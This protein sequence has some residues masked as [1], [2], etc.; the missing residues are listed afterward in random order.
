MTIHPTALVD[1]QAELAADV[2]VGAFSIIGP[3]VRL[4]AG[5]KIAPHVL[6]AGHT[7]LGANNTVHS[8][9]SLGSA[10]QDKKY[11]GE[12]TRLEIGDGNTFFQGMT[13]SLGTAQDV[14][15]TRIGD[16]NWFMA[17]A[18]IAHDCQVGSHTIFANA[19]T[20]GGHVHV[21]DYAI[22]G[23]LAAVHQFCVV[24]EHVMAGGGSIIV[25]DVP[26]YVMT[27]GNHASPS[28]VNSEGLRRRGF[29]AEA[30]NMVRRAYKQLYRQGMTY[31]E[32]K[33]AILADL[34]G[35][36]ELQPFA[37]FFARATRGIIR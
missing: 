11:K 5:C 14:G 35:H 23:G 3:H 13:V 8:F 33:A 7:T 15:V 34:D 18:H 1:P 31:E 27:S 4:A 36:P 2:E 32:A 37:D 30:I 16:D 25:Q 12:P 28:G 10:P 19:V 24:G 20:L 29:S 6:I 26:P 21:G 17:Y 9:C 22:L